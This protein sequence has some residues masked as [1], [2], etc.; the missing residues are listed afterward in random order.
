[1]PHHTLHNS[2]IEITE[3]FVIVSNGQCLSCMTKLIAWKL[4]IALH[5]RDASSA[6]ERQMIMWANGTTAQFAAV[7]W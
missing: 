2:Y 5:S 4:D 3:Q 6:L 1:V 7:W